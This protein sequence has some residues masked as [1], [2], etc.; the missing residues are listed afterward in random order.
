MEKEAGW[1]SSMGTEN[2]FVSPCCTLAGVEAVR[3]N[4]ASSSSTSFA[5]ATGRTP[6]AAGCRGEPLGTVRTRLQSASKA[7][8]AVTSFQCMALWLLPNDSY[9]VLNDQ[10]RHCA[11]FCD[12]IRSPKPTIAWRALYGLNVWA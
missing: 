7:G 2:D 10:L 12:T 6:M 1:A 9:L 3:A 5:A 8:C 11:A 4:S